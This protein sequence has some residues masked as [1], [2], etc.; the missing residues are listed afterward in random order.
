M[1]TGRRSTPEPGYRVVRRGRWR[2]L[3]GPDGSTQSAMDP[4]DPSRAVLAYQQGF[5]ATIAAG[6][7]R[8]VLVVGLGAGVMP[9]SVLRFIP[10]ARVDTVEIDP[11]VIEIAETRFDFRTTPQCRLHLEDARRFL[12]R[13]T[14]AW[15]LVLLD[16]YE[17]SEPPR[18]LMTLEFLQLVR[19]RLT[20]GGMAA[21]NVWAPKLNRLYGSVLRTWQEVFGALTVLPC[22][23]DNN[24]IVCGAALDR[25]AMFTR[26]A[27]LDP[28]GALPSATWD[29]VSGM[30]RVTARP[31]LESKVL[32]D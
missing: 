23:K 28:D 17:G 25:E 31:R 20:P 22:A 14:E 19:D 6:R 3:L 10:D 32:R 8:T 21:A 7:P 11:E 13:T 24:R 16:A 12:E 9:R 26:L 5:L 2:V 29:A 1:R 27:E 4:A 18:H 15:D 30:R